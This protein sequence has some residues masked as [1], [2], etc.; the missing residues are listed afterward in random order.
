MHR[1]RQAIDRSLLLPE[2]LQNEQEQLPVALARRR[3]RRHRLRQVIPRHAMLWPRAR[4]H[5]ETPN[6]PRLGRA[7]KKPFSTRRIINF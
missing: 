3:G 5:D 6:T 4:D 1:R 2:S 7:A